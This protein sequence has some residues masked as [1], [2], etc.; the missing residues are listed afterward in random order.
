MYVPIRTKSTGYSQPHRGSIYS[1][2]AKW[3]L[4]PKTG[5][6]I[7]SFQKYGFF[8]KCFINFLEVGNKKNGFFTWYCLDYGAL[9]HRQL[10]K[11]AFYRVEFIL[12]TYRKNILEDEAA[13]S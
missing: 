5:L 10:G 13:T 8:K 7:T 1:Y 4:K 9:P 3:I 2:I 6:K 11:L 12:N